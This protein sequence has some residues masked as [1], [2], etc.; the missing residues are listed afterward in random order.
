MIS[1]CMCINV[2]IDTY[3]PTLTDIYVHVHI[4]V[5]VHMHDIHAIDIYSVY[6]C[7]YTYSMCIMYVH[8]YTY[9]SICLFWL[10]VLPPS[11][12]PSVSTLS[13]L[14][15]CLVF[16][17]DWNIFLKTSPYFLQISLGW[18]FLLASPDPFHSSSAP[19]LCFWR[20]TLRDSTHGLSCPW[21]P[22]NG[23]WQL[24]AGDGGG[25]G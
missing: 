11:A 7:T 4:C 1:P 21:F 9:T 3:M 25:G 22:F 19:A 5:C 12:S 16:L 24:P 6:T 14:T 13:H 17:L 10:H 2:Y 18:I 8:M 15:T 20:L 23:Q